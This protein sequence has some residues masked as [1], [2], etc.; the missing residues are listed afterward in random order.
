[1]QCPRCK[2][3]FPASELRPIPLWLKLSSFPFAWRSGAVRQEVSR[4]YCPKC[5]RSINAALFFVAFMVVVMLVLFIAQR[6]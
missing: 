3:E 2:R 5:R 6:L 4:E 1:M